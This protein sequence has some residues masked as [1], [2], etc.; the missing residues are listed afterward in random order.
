MEFIPFAEETDYIGDI[1]KWVFE[2]VCRQKRQWEEYGYPNIPVALN[3]SSKM[4]TQDG[5]FSAVEKTLKE[6]DIKGDEIEFEITETAIMV[7]LEKSIKVLHKLKEIG[8]KIALD[9]FGTGYSSLTYLQKLPI[10][11]L[12][13]DCE[14]I[15]N[16][17][18]END[19]AYIF[20]AVVDLAHNLGFKVIAEGVETKEQLAFL[21]KNNCDI[22]QGYYFG[23]AVPISELHC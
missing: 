10:D 13:I 8:I 14:F 20:K 4:L 1:G 19:E 11:T 17:V 16:I 6:F 5:L 7:D 15:K 2:T 12:K 18:D 22:A 3:I 23:K 21:K 9:D